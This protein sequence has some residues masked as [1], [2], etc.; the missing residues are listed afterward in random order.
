M[1][2]NLQISRTVALSIA[3]HKLYHHQSLPSDFDHNMGATKWIQSKFSRIESW[4]KQAKKLKSPQ[5]EN[6]L[7][8]ILDKDFEPKS[9]FS[10]EVSGGGLTDAQLAEM[11]FRD[12]CG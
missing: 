7:R 1:L 4:I 8:A 9:Y 5:R 6:K 10:S 12:V 2:T 11:K 3:V